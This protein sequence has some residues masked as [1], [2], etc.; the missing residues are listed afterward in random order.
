MTISEPELQA[1]TVK[2]EMLA[3]RARAHQRFCTVCSA[4]ED[5]SPRTCGRREQLN[6]LLRAARALVDARQRA[7][8]RA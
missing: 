2:A 8:S 1:L 6:R 3:A 4:P 7:L 5:G